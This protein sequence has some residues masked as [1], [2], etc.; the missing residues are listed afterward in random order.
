MKK[1]LFE[2][3]IKY[4]LELEDFSSLE[5]IEIYVD[6][7]HRDIECAVEDFIKNSTEFNYNEYTCN[8]WGVV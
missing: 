7:L 4:Y 6:F 8:Y 2:E 3:T 5:E 1:P